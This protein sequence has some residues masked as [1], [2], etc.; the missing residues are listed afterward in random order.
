MSKT[1]KATPLAAQP[2]GAR[3]DG[4]ATR[5]RLLEIAGE[6]FATQ[7][8]S[9]TTSKLICEQAGVPVA[10]VN[11][12]FGSRDGLYAAVLLEAH[13]RLFSLELIENAIAG[14]AQPAERLQAALQFFVN[15]VSQPDRP[16]C[17]GV[18]LREV[19]SPSALLPV[20]V[21][22]GIQPKAAFMLKVVADFIGLPSDHPAVQRCLMFSVLP[23]IAILL[24]PATLPARVL[25]AAF[26]GAENNFAA[27]FL[28][29]T[30]AGLKAVSALYVNGQAS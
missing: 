8:Y 9:G 14:L 7:G 29:H 10:S 26:E 27:D 30:M 25:P 11:Y 21:E 20:L 28:T 19:L 3:A 24:A 4:E 15:V 18:V 5:Q 1:D 16:W 12:H 23:C 17:Y 22:K 6:A 13:N 2:K